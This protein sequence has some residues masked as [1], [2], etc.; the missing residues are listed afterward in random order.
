MTKEHAALF[1]G[2]FNECVRETRF[3]KFAID[4]LCTTPLETL[5]QELATAWLSIQPS[6]EELTKSTAP[7]T[8][9]NTKDKKQARR[10]I[11]LQLR[12]EA[13]SGRSGPTSRR[14]R[15][16]WLPFSFSHE[17][18]SGESGELGEGEWIEVVSSRHRIATTLRRVSGRFQTHQ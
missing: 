5:R 7:T 8:R 3:E 14:L 9:K 10:R 12:Q 16:R 2:E 17:G 13:Q 11:R 4:A 1:A 6:Q 15:V 18:D